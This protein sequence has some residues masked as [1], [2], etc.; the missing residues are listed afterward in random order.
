MSKSLTVIVP[1]YN[2]AA[3]L[4][5]LIPNLMQ[6][7]QKQ[8]WKV[9][10]VNDGSKDVSQKV[11]E[12]FQEQYDHQIIHNKVNKGYGGAIK[13]G[14]RKASTD[15][16]VTIDADGQHSIED[17]QKLYEYLIENDADMVVG[18]RPDSSSGFYRRFGKNVIRTIAKILLPINIHD[19][20]SGMKIYDAQLAKRY[21]DLCPN[22][23][24]YSDIIALVF[25]SYRHLVL[26][27]PIEIQQRMT[28]ESTI[29]TRTAFQTVLEILNV[30]M[31]F[32][33]LRIFLPIA[34]VSIFIGFLW[35]L[36]ILL[37]GKGLSVG[38]LFFILSG[39]LFFL[40]GLL[41]EQLSNIRKIVGI[42][43]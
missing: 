32:N 41:A 21:L 6:A 30:T 18:K 23:M 43:N 9:I 14:I 7:A 34:V 25:I 31:L 35:G 20:N 15:L 40:M 33:P 13:E 42:K 4:P 37:Q 12:D 39:I 38:A 16:V 3:N 24:A 8:Q 36:P 1:S 28:G 22:S 29:S 26:E 5:L 2:E 10:F 19:I 11:L 17:V 27:H